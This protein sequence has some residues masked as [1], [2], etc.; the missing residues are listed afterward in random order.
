[1]AGQLLAE[2]R[3]VSACDGDGAAG[4]AASGTAKAGDAPKRPGAAGGHPRTDG[5]KDPGQSGHESPRDHW[6][7]HS[8][9]AGGS[10]MRRAI[11]FLGPTTGAAVVAVGRG[12][13][14]PG[15]P[16]RDSSVSGGAVRYYGGLTVRVQPKRPT[17]AAGRRATPKTRVRAA[18][19]A[20]NPG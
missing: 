7:Y 18:P 4:R 2:A 9:P 13:T 15:K 1:M 16:A 8:R 17:R 5:Q 19:L 11:H 14:A 3:R 20:G 12:T 6:H 10:E